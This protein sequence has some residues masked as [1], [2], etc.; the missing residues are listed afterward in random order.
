MKPCKFNGCT[1]KIEA[2][3]TYCKEHQEFIDKVKE[4]LDILDVHYH[5]EMV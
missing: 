3:H 4:V 5:S 2:W 1:E